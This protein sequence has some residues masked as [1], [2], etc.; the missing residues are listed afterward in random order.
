MKNICT[1]NPEGLSR[2]EI[3]NKMRYLHNAITLAE[4]HNGQCVNRKKRFWLLATYKCNCN[5]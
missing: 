3:L 5:N 2:E 4:S 1:C